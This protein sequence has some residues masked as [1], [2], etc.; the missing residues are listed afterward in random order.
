MTHYMFN[1][2]YKN[3]KICQSCTRSTRRHQSH[4]MAYPSNTLAVGHFDTWHS[5]TEVRV[6]EIETSALHIGLLH[7][8]TPSIILLYKASLAPSV[9][10]RSQKIFNLH[11]FKMHVDWHNDHSHHHVKT[12]NMSNLVFKTYSILASQ[13]LHHSVQQLSL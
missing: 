1:Y 6:K 9:N 7:L 3:A 8:T 5:I 4:V 11:V 12:C 13:G 10:T 2:I